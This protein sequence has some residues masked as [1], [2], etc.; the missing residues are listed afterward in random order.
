MNAPQRPRLAVALGFA[1]LAGCDQPTGD[2]RPRSTAPVVAQ[3]EAPTPP[4]AP[5]PE[6]K[7]REI[8]GRRTQDVRDAAK[9]AKAGGVE[10]APRITAT[11]PI[12]LV[13]NAYVSIIGR[14]AQL[15]IESALNLYKAGND[16][17]YPKTTEEFMDKVI[18][19]NNIALPKLPEYQDY[20]YKAEEHKLVIMEYPDR[21]AKMNYPK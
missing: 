3:P 20:A 21:K 16:G 19:A 14:S 9:E 7:S 17:E 12:L 2:T 11:D 8:L 10:T 13:G 6:P 15:N 18:K 4:P 1:L 5:A